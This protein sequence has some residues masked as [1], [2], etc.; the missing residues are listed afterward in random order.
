MRENTPS[1]ITG[2]SIGWG[3][4]LGRVSSTL[5]SHLTGGFKWLVGV[6]PQEF[7]DFT[8]GY[9][10]QIR[11]RLWLEKNVLHRPSSIYKVR[12]RNYGSE[13]QKDR[14]ATYFFFSIARVSEM[15][16]G[17]LKDLW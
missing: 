2:G 12:R 3:W 14:I 10:R 11:T 16:K 9:R 13:R 7:D 6:C 8:A 4:P 17:F 15:R 1:V 5:A